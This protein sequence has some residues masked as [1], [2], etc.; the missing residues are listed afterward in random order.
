LISGRW[1][2]KAGQKRRRYYQLTANGR[3]VLN[4]RR[5]SWNAFVTAVER[6]AGPGYA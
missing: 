2:E 4:A 6:A 1:V 3:K 5:E